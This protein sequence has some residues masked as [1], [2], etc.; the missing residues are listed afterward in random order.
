MKL[1]TNQINNTAVWRTVGQEV[2]CAFQPNCQTIFFVESNTVYSRAIVHNSNQFFVIIFQNSKTD[3]F[4]FSGLERSTGQESECFGI[5]DCQ[6]NFISSLSNFGL[7][8]IRK[9]FGWATNNIGR[10]QRLANER[11]IAHYVLR[12]RERYF[13]FCTTAISKIKVAANNYGNDGKR[14]QS[15][16]KFIR[17][18]SFHAIKKFS[19]PT[20][21]MLSAN[22]IKTSNFDFSNV[23][24]SVGIEP[25]FSPSE[26]D[27]LSVERRG[28]VSV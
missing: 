17:F 5:F 6:G 2:R 20:S 14:S 27:I 11:I 1:S 7:N 24:P 13:H 15:L 9:I 4:G 23:V 25:T 12:I 18:F 22:K 28:L 21:T 8:A 19:S 26:G 10:K 16:I 3:S